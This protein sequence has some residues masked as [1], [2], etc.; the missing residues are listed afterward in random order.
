MR[1]SR[2]T[3]RASASRSPA[4]S[5]SR[6]RPGCASGP[7]A[8]AR[9]PFRSGPPRPSASTARC[10]SRCG[11]TD[12]ETALP[13]HSAADMAGE[14]VKL[15]VQ[16]RESLGSADSR[17]L[18]KQGLIPGVLYGRSQPVAICVAERELRRA[19][20]GA[21]GLHAIL[22]VVVEGKQAS[23]SAILKEYQQDKVRGYVTHVDLQEVRLDQPIQATV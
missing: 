23:H 2:P 10:R 16:E 6:A 12:K 8:P 4:D 14:R 18:R 7:A 17:R 5:A 19:L 3:F 13:L 9:R 21:G 20:T 1:A 15:T 11:G 22:D